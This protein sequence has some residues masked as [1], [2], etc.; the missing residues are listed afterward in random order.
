MKG[1]TA[2]ILVAGLSSVLIQLTVLRQLYT[3]F[4]GNELVFGVALGSWLLL[5]SIGSLIGKYAN[6]LREKKSAYITLQAFLGLIAPLI[7]YL[8]AVSRSYFAV[9]GQMTGPIEAT[10]ASIIVLAPYCLISGFMVV[11]AQKINI[12]DGN[13]SEGYGASKVYSLESMGSLAGGLIYSLIIV[14]VFNPYEIGKIVLLINVLAAIILAYKLNK[15]NTPKILAFTALLALV[16]YTA[17]DLGN[18]ANKILY[19]N[20]EVVLQKDSPYGK[21]AVTKSGE[22]I[23]YYESGLPLY[24]TGDVVWR[25][26]TVHYAMVQHKNPRRVLMVSGGLAEAFNEVLKYP[27]VEV[28][29]YIELDPMIMGLAKKGISDSRVRAYNVDGRQYIKEKKYTYD[30]IL[31]NLPDPST[32]QLSRYFTVELFN[33]TRKLLNDEGILSLSLSSS[34]NYMSPESRKLNSCIYLSLKEVYMNVIIIPGNRNYFLASSSNLTH[35][36]AERID[37]LKLDTEYV[38]KNY[39]AGTLT[40]ERIEQTNKLIDM[41]KGV[42]LNKDLKP[43]SYYYYLLYW[44]RHFGLEIW[45]IV[46]IILLFFVILILRLRPLPLA[47]YSGGYAGTTLEITLI[48]WFQVIHGYVYQMINFIVTAFMLGLA[49]GAWYGTKKIRSHKRTNTKKLSLCLG[50]Y[51]FIVAAIIEFMTKSTAIHPIIFL[52][53]TAASGLIVGT[54]FASASEEYSTKNEDTMS[55]LYSADLSGAFFS[56]LLTS[57]FF[58]PLYGL[59]FAAIIAGTLNVISSLSQ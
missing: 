18:E 39:L 40:E 14:T 35:K 27:S 54:L 17:A 43:I 25:E 49:V 51:S 7:I 1:L 5:T 23:S 56:S 28:L 9:A 10:F 30:V 44:M 16:A 4:Y 37:E 41:E 3:S 15:K 11:L 29:D 55:K 33:E 13:L 59:T 2:A 36:I 26:E 50:I 8:A 52:L 45:H 24:S 47:V 46:A 22:Q 58:I 19:P 48:I 32:A 12:E 6:K 53:L 42:E 38:N 21:I 20:Q 57:I 34:A 31:L